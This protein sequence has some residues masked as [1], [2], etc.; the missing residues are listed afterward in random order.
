MRNEYKSLVVKSKG[1]RPLGRPGRRWED[2]TVLERQ[3][4]GFSDKIVRKRSEKKRW[5]IHTKKKNFEIFL[6]YNV[7]WE[8]K[9]RD[10]MTGMATSD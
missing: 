6:N 3:H 7:Y 8:D 5:Q 4:S 9:E 2:N 1:N 10:G